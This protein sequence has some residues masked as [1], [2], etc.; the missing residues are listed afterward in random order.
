MTAPVR[1]CI[2]CGRQAEQRAL[3]R[4]GIEG[5]HVV[6]D[7]ERKQ[8]GRGA[9]LHPG[10]ECLEKAI[11]RRAFMRAFRRGAVAWDAGALRVQLTGSARKD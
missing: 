1:T 11:K 5:E 6:V 2:G 7:A 4:L 8:G 10:S 9:W 3:V